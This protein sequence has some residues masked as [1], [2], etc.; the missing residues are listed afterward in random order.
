MEFRQGWLPSLFADEFLHKKITIKKITTLCFLWKE[1]QPN[2]Y[3]YILGNCIIWILGLLL[4]IPI[5]SL[6]FSF[7]SFLLR[8]SWICGVWCWMR[9]SLMR[10]W[11]L[12]SPLSASVWAIGSGIRIAGR[13]LAGRPGRRVGITRNRWSQPWRVWA[14]VCLITHRSEPHGYFGHFIFF[15]SFLFIMPL[16]ILIYSI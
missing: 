7:S 1:N 11:W 10:L 14:S 8:A 5:S 16:L 4:S 12:F 6:S 3:I 13:I 15:L 2:K 9:V